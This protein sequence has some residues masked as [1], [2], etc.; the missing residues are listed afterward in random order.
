MS[1]LTEE[2]EKLV[3]LIAQAFAK[4]HGAEEPHI[5]ADTVLE[6]AKTLSTDAAKPEEVKAPEA[7]EAPAT[8]TE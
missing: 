5:F 8:T 6:H 2:Y 4:T 1:F 7:P 3:H